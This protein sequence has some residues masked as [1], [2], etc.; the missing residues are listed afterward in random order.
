MEALRFKQRNRYSVEI[1]ARYRIDR[2]AGARNAYGLRLF[3]F[4]PRGFELSPATYDR[5]GF[6]DQLRM[7]LRFDTPRFSF[8]ELLDPDSALSPLARLK[9]GVPVDAAEGA[10]TSR[11]VH[12]SKLLGCIFKSL[13]RDYVHAV[14]ESPDSADRKE[15]DLIRQVAM[16]FRRVRSAI[17]DQGDAGLVRHFD[18][19]DEY[20][21]LL[22]SRYCTILLHEWG[23]TTN[24]TATQKSIA[25]VI[26]AEEEYRRSRRFPTVPADISSERDLEEYVY[27]EKMLKRYA[28]EALFFEVSRTDTGRRTEQ[29]LYAAAAGVAMIVATGI[30]FFGQQ[31]FGSFTTSLFVLLVLGYMVKDRVKD[32]FRDL[33]TRTVGSFFTV[34]KSTIRDPKRRSLRI[35]AVHERIGFRHRRHR[36]AQV[37]NARNRG[38]FERTLFA[39]DDEQVLE[40]SK[41]IALNARTI[42]AL[43]H[44]IDAVADINVVDIRPFLRHL[45]TQYG[46]VPRAL[47]P[48]EGSPQRIAPR[49]VQRVYHLTMIVEYDSPGGT[50]LQRYRLIVHGRGIK[51]IESVGDGGT[52]EHGTWALV[53]E[54]G[55]L[56]ED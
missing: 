56:D 40:Y 2:S 22:V 19:I 20:L 31:R 52:V 15:I 42:S 23:D 24:R 11:L 10:D 33:L 30:A 14:R 17:V 47:V 39:E 53:D 50:I 55:D 8:E 44:R 29:I 5:R 35:A 51:R 21:S 41:T 27:R 6:L 7:F 37:Q 28:T 4:F 3:F 46:I 43:H 54:I 49:V 26:E 38:A 1:K 36:P 34:R 48:G 12:E 45:N 18:L 32:L 13:L 9:A 25:R 16:R